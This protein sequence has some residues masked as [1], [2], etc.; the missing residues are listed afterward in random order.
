MDSS[1]CTCSQNP[2]RILVPS[3]TVKESSCSQNLI[4]VLTHKRRKCLDS[5]NVAESDKNTC[6][7]M[8]VLDGRKHI[9]MHNQ[10]NQIAAAIKIPKQD[11]C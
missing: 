8:M 6:T 7:I 2:I 10:P 9:C 5:S 3:G 1:N 4:G 11:R